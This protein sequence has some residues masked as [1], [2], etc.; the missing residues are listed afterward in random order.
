MRDR[1]F[2]FGVNTCRFNSGWRRTGGASR[3]FQ[4]GSAGPETLCAS[5]FLKPLPSEA[6][7]GQT[8]MP[9]IAAEI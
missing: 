1:I 8:G 2:V 7:E 3:L 6:G 4:Q 9:L 5:V